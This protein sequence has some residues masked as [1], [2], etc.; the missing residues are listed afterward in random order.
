MHLLDSFI[1]LCEWVRQEED[2]HDGQN[3]CDEYESNAHEIDHVGGFIPGFIK[4]AA[5]AA[6]FFFREV[7]HGTEDLFAFNDVESDKEDHLVDKHP[8][9]RRHTDLEERQVNEDLHSVDH[10]PKL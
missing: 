6:I 9:T 5:D 7:K 1:H 3:E 10:S 2:E 4:F 8:R